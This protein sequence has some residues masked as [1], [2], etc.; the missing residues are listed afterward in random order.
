[1]GGSQAGRNTGLQGPLI[2]TRVFKGKQESIRQKKDVPE[3][4]K[5]EQRGKKVD[6]AFRY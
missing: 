4:G 2:Q 3:R 6:R 1:M 5:R